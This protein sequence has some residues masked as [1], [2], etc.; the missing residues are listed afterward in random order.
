MGSF[1][2]TAHMNSEGT[3][4]A[5]NERSAWAQLVALGLAYAAI[6]GVSSSDPTNATR[7]A[8][9]FGAA[10]VL[11]IV[12][13]AATHALLATTT[14]AQ[15]DDERDDAIRIRANRLSDFIH[16][17]GAITAFLMLL[18]Q[19]ILLGDNTSTRFTLHPLFV[20][21]L[22]LL[23]LFVAEFFRLAQQIIGYRRG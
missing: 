5:F 22:L 3:G 8:V 10:V 2:Y 1:L 11:Q 16:G 13:I 4:A 20:G 18:V 14:E 7:L 19:Q 21:H 9:A 12:V 17:F 23:S 6:V 15:P